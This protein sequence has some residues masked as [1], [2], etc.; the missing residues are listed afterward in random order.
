MTALKTQESFKL[1]RFLS[2]PLTEIL[3][4]T[5]I[6]PNQITVLSLLVGLL[7]GFLFSRGQYT[8]SISGAL[9]F[10]VAVI[11][12]NCDGEIAR[13]KNLK[14]VF[15]GWLDVIVDVIVD[16]TLFSGI[17]LG[18]FKSGFHFWILATGLLCVLGSITNCW[19]VIIQKNKGFGPAVHDQP[20]P[21]GSDRNKFYYQVSNALREGDASWF[22]VLFTVFNGT[23]YLLL[24]A[25]FYMQLLW[26]TGLMLNLKWLFSVHNE[27]Y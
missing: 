23:Q 10:Q 5:P 12:D 11:L 4:L 2:R 6:T 7:S 17:T 22:V 8:S 9:V 25:S 24:C 18:L 21:Q 26:L 20:H 1:N 13:A 15:G 16:I 14:S 19:I 27:N 3:L